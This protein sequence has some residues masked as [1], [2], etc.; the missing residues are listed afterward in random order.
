[1]SVS[2]ADSVVFAMRL[3]PDKDENTLDKSKYIEYLYTMKGDNYMLGF[4]IN[5]VGMQDLDFCNW[6]V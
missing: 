6:L 4:S 3:Y 1:M 5:I 2:G